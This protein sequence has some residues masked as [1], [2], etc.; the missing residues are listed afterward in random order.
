MATQDPVDQ[1]KNKLD[2]KDVIA[3]YI[4]LEKSGVNLKARCPFHQERTPSFFVS[5]SRQIWR[6]FGCGEGGDIFTF[7]EKIE[8][9]DFV[10]ALQR[11]GQKAG[12]DVKKQDPKIRN[13]KNK[14]LEICDLVSK[15]F[16]R[17]LESKN[18]ELVV[19]YFASRGINKQSI[20]DFR[21]GYAPVKSDNLI[22]FLRKKNYEHLDMERAGVAFK[23]DIS[24][25]WLTRFRSRIIFPI[26]SVAGDVVGFGAR[27]LTEELAL[28]MNRKVKFDTAKYINSPQTNIYDKSNI[29]YGLNEAKIAIRQQDVCIVVE[30]YTDVILAHQEGFKNVVAASGTSLTA[31]QLDLI[32]RFTKNLI[33]SF[34]MD[35][36]G[37]SATKRGIDL[38]QN[39]GF[40]VKVLIL[41][42][43]KDPADVIFEDKNKWEEALKN[44]KSIMQFY[45]DGAFDRFDS[46]SAEGKREIGKILSPLIANIPSRIEQAHWV[47]DLSTR[48]KVGQ[49]DVWE[50]VKVSNRKSQATGY[51]EASKDNVIK[52]QQISKKE[53][54]AQYMLLAVLKNGKLLKEV[55]NLDETIKPFKLLKVA[56]G[57]EK[58]DLDKFIKKIDKDDRILVDQLL[59]EADIKGGDWT[60]G[61]FR[62]ILTSYRKAI[63]EEELKELEA[64]VKQKERDGNEEE[65]K[66]L[67][68]KFHKKTI[69]LYNA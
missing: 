37:D 31:G 51:E 21:L 58:F 62:A 33:T 15:Y 66:K 1:I 68:D 54:L 53:L 26:S 22:T 64:Q 8:G 56:K 35:I 5:P 12:V 38:A 50:E 32:S 34:D 63:V 60:K 46:S 14:S 67:L 42:E 9:V 41:E 19:E 61:H 69:E 10:D 57:M 16:H 65:V 3:N 2:I 11:L 44:T 6:C 25:D 43:G 29:L 20:E 49:E 39:M 4:K 52:K 13:Q 7:I 47:S 30:G 48:L 59:L 23:S 45:F 18:G 17:Q 40:D 28:K 24:G 36:A 55:K 27:S